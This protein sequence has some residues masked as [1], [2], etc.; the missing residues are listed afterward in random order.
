MSALDWLEWPM[1]LGLPVAALWAMAAV[2]FG[3]GHGGRE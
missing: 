2:L 3:W 1:R